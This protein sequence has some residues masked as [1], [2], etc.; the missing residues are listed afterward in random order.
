MSRGPMLT[1]VGGGDADLGRP[2]SITH[3]RG[4]SL[5]SNLRVFVCKVGT[6]ILASRDGKARHRGETIHFICHQYSYYTK[7]KQTHFCFEIVK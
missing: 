7:R 4:K 3:S 1:D 6:R 5:L 2:S